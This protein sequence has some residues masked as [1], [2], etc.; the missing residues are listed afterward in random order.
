MTS[1]KKLFSQTVFRKM[2]ICSSELLVKRR[3]IEGFFGQ[4]EMLNR[5]FACILREENFCLILQ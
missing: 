4:M 3:S 2:A 5:Y 1:G